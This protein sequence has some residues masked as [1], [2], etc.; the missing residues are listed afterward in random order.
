MQKNLFNLPMT[1]VVIMVTS[2]LAHASSANLDANL[3]ATIVDTTCEMKLVGG[4][5]DNTKQTATVSVPG[6]S[7]PWI[8]LAD[9]Q[10]GKAKVEFKLAIVECPPSLTSLKATIKGTPSGLSPT[11]LTNQIAKT[12]GGAD[13]AALEI[14]RTTATANPFTINSE[15][16]A[17]RLVWT[18]TEI[19]QKEVSLVATLRETKAGAM[20]IGKFKTIATFEFSYE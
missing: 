19:D 8:P 16:D 7:N 15:V 2:G 5:G 14:A 13:Y 4:T 11:G 17:Q 20:T 12:D 3:T 10:A 1:A 18:K 9:G 6:R